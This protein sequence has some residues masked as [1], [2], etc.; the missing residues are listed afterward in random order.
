MG[1]LSDIRDVLDAGAAVRARNM[2]DTLDTE[3]SH[4]KRL[5]VLELLLARG[6]L[7]HLTGS[8]VVGHLRKQSNRHSRQMSGKPLSDLRPLSCSSS[9]A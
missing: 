2:L 9:M 3:M 7:I 4:H 8:F 1:T 6:T 5:D